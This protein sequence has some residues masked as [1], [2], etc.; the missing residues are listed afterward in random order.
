MVGEPPPASLFGSHYH[1]PTIPGQE[2]AMLE[3]WELITPSTV[4]SAF[5]TAFMNRC[6]PAEVSEPHQPSVEI[7]LAEVAVTRV[8]PK[9]STPAAGTP[10]APALSNYSALFYYKTTGKNSAFEGHENILSSVM[11]V[12]PAFS[13]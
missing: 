1:P 6:S 5:M 2:G 13:L 11:Q 7:A 4:R 12:I 9:A 10:I 8:E 3:G